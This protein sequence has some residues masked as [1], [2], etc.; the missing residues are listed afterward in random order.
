MGGLHAVIAVGWP[1]VISD[2]SRGLMAV[3]GCAGQRVSPRC[4]SGFPGVS[5]A[6]GARDG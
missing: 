3:R 4:R 2:R 1:L 6:E 5:D